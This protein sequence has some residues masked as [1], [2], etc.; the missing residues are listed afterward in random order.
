MSLARQK[1]SRLHLEVRTYVVR[2][3]EVEECGSLLL[4]DLLLFL[5]LLLEFAQIREAAGVR[6]SPLE[7]HLPQEHVQGERSHDE[8]RVEGEP[9]A[10][11]LHAEPDVC[12][13]RARG[14][15]ERARA[16][17]AAGIRSD[18]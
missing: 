16:A 18:R 3:F 17:A 15:G 12:R 9:G 8:P 14:D 10:P 7:P 1:Y 2:V 11:G 5:Q 4:P 13:S 6:R